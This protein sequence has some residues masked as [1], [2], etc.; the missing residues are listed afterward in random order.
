[1]NVFTI[2]FLF[3]NVALAARPFLNE[4][5][6]GIEDALKIPTNG[7]LPP[8]DRMLGLPDFDY[9]AR[10]TMGFGPYA[11]IVHGA[12]SESS[13]RNNLETFNRFR[14]RPRV[15][16][17][18]TNID[19]SLKTSILGHEFDQP[20]FISPF[21]SAGITNKAAEEGLVK[22][23]AQQNVLYIVTLPMLLVSLMNLDEEPPRALFAKIEA[24]GFKAIVL[25][26]DSAGDRTAYRSRRLLPDTSISRDPRYTFM[27][28]EFYNELQ[29]MTSLPIIPKGIQTVEDAR[30]AIKVGAPAIFLSNHGGRALDGS[31]SPVEIAWEIYQEDPEIFNEIEVYADGGVRYGTDVMKLLALGVRAV[32]LGR[33]FMYANLYGTAGIDRAISLLESEITSAGANLGLSDIR[34]IDASYLKLT[35]TQWNN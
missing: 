20:F 32:G 25:T 15:M 3:A 33:P 26:V 28:W 10:E 34:D 9:L 23:A 13:Y 31:P 29:A 1:M 5:D 6:T 8:I 30:M 22:G 4:P 11:Y 14:F 7:S 16:V 35:S 12:G 19:T 21:A 18:I 27:T 17:N 2:L 24:A